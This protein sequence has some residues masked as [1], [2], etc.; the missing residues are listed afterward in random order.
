MAVLKRLPGPVRRQEKDIKKIP[1]IIISFNQ[2]FYL[3]KLVDFL[4]ESGYNNIIIADNASTYPPLIEYLD[5]ICRHVKVIKFQENYGHMVVFRKSKVFRKYTRGFYAVTDADVLPSEECPPDFMAYFKR[6][7]YTY[8]RVNKVGFSLDTK[9]IPNTH[10]Y[11]DQIIEWES[12]YWERKT[13]EG[14]YYADID[15]TFALYRPMSFKWIKVSFMNAVRTKAPYTAIHGGWIL[16]PG[17]LTREQRYYMETASESSSW[18]L[19]ESGKL[20]SKIY[21]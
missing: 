21:R 5:D 13:E 7:L 6:L 20:I 8:K 1:V 11:K 2:L 18:K 19:D 12:K 14:N 10:P 3:R 9:R 4:L 17:N 15:T 16:D